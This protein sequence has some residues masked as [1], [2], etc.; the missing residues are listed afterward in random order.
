MSDIEKLNDQELFQLY[1]HLN[2][3]LKELEDLKKK[4]SE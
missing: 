3:F 4:E 2:E 1:K